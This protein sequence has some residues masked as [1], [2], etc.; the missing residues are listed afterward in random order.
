M[1]AAI[2]GGSATEF[3]LQIAKT[4]G[5][6]AMAQHAC[7]LENCSLIGSFIEN[8]HCVANNE[9]PISICVVT[10]LCSVHFSS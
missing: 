7:T 1:N 8:G 4:G 9:K 3:S 5:K 10:I 2:Q 6:V